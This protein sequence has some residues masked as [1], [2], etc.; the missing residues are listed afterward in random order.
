MVE[1]NGKILAQGNSFEEE[2]IY[3]DIVQS[4]KPSM[5]KSS[6]ISSVK[7][8]ASLEKLKKFVQL[9][10]CIYREKSEEEEIYLK[11]HQLNKSTQLHLNL[12]AIII[13]A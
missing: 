6:R 9:P 3:T 12:K 2:T 11:H 8:P 5:A 7:A 10:A 13:N 1:A 4:P